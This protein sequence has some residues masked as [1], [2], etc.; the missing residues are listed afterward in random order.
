MSYLA[1]GSP[2]CGSRT[3]YLTTNP[4]EGLLHEVF[5]AITITDRT[6]DEVQKAILITIDQ[7]VK[8]EPLAVEIPR[9]QLRRELRPVRRPPPCHTGRPRR[10]PRQAGTGTRLQVQVVDRPGQLRSRDRAG[11]EQEGRPQPS[12][13]GVGASHLPRQQ[14]QGTPHSQAACRGDGVRLEHPPPT[15]A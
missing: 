12:G 2:S 15:A 1:S 14:R 5:R 13:Q 10:R 6:V 7:L 4:H 8:S 9:D 11:C 3:R